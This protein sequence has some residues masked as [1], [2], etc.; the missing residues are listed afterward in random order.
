M[1]PPRTSSDT[2]QNLPTSGSLFA[3]RQSGCPGGVYAAC[4]RKPESVE[5]MANRASIA[6]LQKEYKLLLKV[7]AWFVAV[8]GYWYR[9][10]VTGLGVLLL[11]E[12]VPNITAH[13]SPTNIL[14]W[15]YALEGPADTEYE[16][17]KSLHCAT[18]AD[19][20]PILVAA[21]HNTAACRLQGAF[22]MARS[23]SL[24][25]CQALLGR[26]RLSTVANVAHARG[27]CRTEPRSFD[28]NFEPWAIGRAPGR[29]HLFP[30]HNERSELACR[31]GS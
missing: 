25:R 17:A 6:R 1:F 26:N 13:P 30:R 2:A 10:C 18:C 21:L 29:N 14:E 22:I 31:A 24:V 12:P 28:P 19:C 7:R 16:G 8:R 5:S 27:R 11:Q 9:L 15:H 23:F 20:R 3:R 4:A